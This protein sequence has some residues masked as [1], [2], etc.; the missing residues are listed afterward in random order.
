VRSIAAL[1]ALALLQAPLALPPTRD[2]LFALFGSYVESLRVQAGIPGLAAAVIDTDGIVWEQAFGQQDLA[3]TL[4]TRTDTPFH[5]DGL[6]Q[7][8]TA[9]LV[10][11]CVQDGHLRLDAPI[12]SFNPNSADGEA[13]VGQVL[14]HTSGPASDPVFSY[15]PDRLDVLASVVS[16]CTGSSFRVAVARTLERLAMTDSMPGPDAASD[17]ALAGDTTRFRNILDR[18]AVP[19]SVDA[20]GRGS[21]SRYPATTLTPSTGLVSTVLDFA[22]FDLALRKGVLLNADTVAAAWRAPLTAGDRPL[23]HGM[24]WFV[25]TYSGEPVVWQFGVG[26]GASS[27]LVVTMPGRGITLI[28]LANSDG[29]AKPATL[30]SGDITASPFARLFFQ[31]LVK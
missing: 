18:L 28:M 27:S 11:R 10:L 22:K 12:K 30:A 1:V 23:P 19:Y 17:A 31:L 3:R 26:S 7:L 16:T 25:Q 14:S 8:V 6:T 15:R 9:T 13:T 4:A 24:G 21:P 29:L 2:Q 20:Q 5:L